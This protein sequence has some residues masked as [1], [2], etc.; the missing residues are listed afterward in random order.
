VIYLPSKISNFL[1]DY[2]T[3]Q[4]RGLQG[5]S[6]SHNPELGS[7]GGLQIPDPELGSPGGLQIPQSRAGVSRGSPDPR[8]RAGVSRGLQTSQ[9]RTLVSRVLQILPVQSLGLYFLSRSS[10]PEPGSLF[11]LQILRSR[12]WVSIFSPDVPIQ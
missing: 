8:S 10:D 6:R 11:S 3:I 4:S 9:S 5:V 7:P 2:L 12:A 1:E